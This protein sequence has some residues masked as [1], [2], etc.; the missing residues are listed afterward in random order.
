MNT[1]RE[2]LIERLHGF[3][4]ATLFEA[5]GRKGMVD[6]TIRAAWPGVLP[7]G[8]GLTVKHATAQAAL[9]YPRN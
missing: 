1:R 2:S 3:D 6:A 4:P 9:Q 8:V 7:C 5:A